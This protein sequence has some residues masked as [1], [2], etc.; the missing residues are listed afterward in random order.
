MFCSKCGNEILDEAVICPKCG[1]ETVSKKTENKEPDEPKTGMG[2]LLAL[3]L[4]LIGLVIGLCLYKENTVARKTFL[5]G[6]GITFGISVVICVIIFAVS[7]AN[8]NSAINDLN[9]SYYG[10]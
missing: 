8:L 3:V 6:W 9:N 2:I 1:C 7:M 4:G 10:Y 5:K